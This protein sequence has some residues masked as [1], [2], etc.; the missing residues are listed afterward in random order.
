MNYEARPTL[1]SLFGSDGAA[2]Q[3]TELFR[4]GGAVVDMMT[5]SFNRAAPSTMRIEEAAHALLFVSTGTLLVRRESDHRWTVV[6]PQT[7]VY[8]GGKTDFSVNFARGD[9]KFYV[10]R[11]AKDSAPALDIW[12]DSRLRKDPARRTARGSIR[13]KPMLSNIASDLQRLIEAMKTPLDNVVPNLYGLIHLSVG[14]TL[15][16]ESEVGLAPLPTDL[17]PVI[18]ALTARVREHPESPWPLK[19]ASD[20]VGYSPFHFSRVF[21]AIVGYGFHEYVD[22]CRTELAVRMLSTTDEPVDIISAE[23]GFGTAQ[24]LR[25]SVKYHL[26]LLPSELRAAPDDTGEPG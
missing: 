16:G 22:R 10:L 20:Q 8:A 9:H 19:D 15:V 26:G 12:I 18:Q 6:A 21:K 23:A 7:I 25:E 14:Y 1:G 3:R 13:S 24:S 11:W 4:T 5:A 17:P 2:L